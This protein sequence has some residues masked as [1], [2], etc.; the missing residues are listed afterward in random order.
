MEYV[1]A[2]L[3]IEDASVTKAYLRRDKTRPEH[4]WQI[5]HVDGW[6][7]FADFREGSVT[8][9]ADL[10]CRGV[11]HCRVAPAE[12]SA[13]AGIHVDPLRRR[14]GWWVLGASAEAYEMPQRWPGWTVEFWQDRWG[15]HVLTAPGR[16]LPPPVDCARALVDV[17]SA[18]ERRREA[19]THP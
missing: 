16:F 13:D 19:R 10:V 8:L 4:R 9:T 11:V 18:A 15:E 12:A 6:H 1:A 14:V 7:D 17:R 2:Q 5:Q 3:G